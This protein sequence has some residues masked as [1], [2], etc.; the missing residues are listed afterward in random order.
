MLLI[1]ATGEMAAFCG[2][3]WFSAR[4]GTKNLSRVGFR[5]GAVTKSGG[6]GLTVSLQDVTLSAGPP[7]QPDGTQDQTVAIANGNASFASNTWIRTGTF[8][9]SRTVTYGD[10][11]AVNVEYDGG[12]RTN[13]DSVIVNTIVAGQTG[14]IIVAQCSHVGTG[15]VTVR[16][17][18]RSYCIQHDGWCRLPRKVDATSLLRRRTG[19]E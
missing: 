3:V 18:R 14:S 6:S 2:R 11:L 16:A 15:L 12:G 9:A 8:S 1:D 19:F 13:P 5:F 4:S 7:M 10:L 17:Q